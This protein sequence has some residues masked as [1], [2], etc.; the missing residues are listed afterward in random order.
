MRSYDLKSGNVLWEAGGMTANVI[1]SPVL[2]DE[3]GIV[4]VMSGFRGNALLAIRLQDASGDIT[5]SGS[6]VWD[7]GQDTP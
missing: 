1:P 6:I 3:S 7:Y 5:N 2:D 4:Y